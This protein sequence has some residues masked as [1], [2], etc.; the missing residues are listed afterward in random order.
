MLVLQYPDAGEGHD[1]GTKDTCQEWTGLLVVAEKTGQVIAMR[2]RVAVRKK[3]S[4]PYAWL[5]GRTQGVLAIVTSAICSFY[6]QSGKPC[7]SL[8]IENC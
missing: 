2:H 1:L 8:A 3:R 4:C 5:A 6:R 7:N